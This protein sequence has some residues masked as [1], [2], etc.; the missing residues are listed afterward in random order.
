M[1]LVTQLYLEQVSQWPTSG[2]HIL[3][4]YDEQH[5]V[6][7]QAYS[8]SIGTFAAQHGYFGDDYKLNRMSWIKPNFLWM[9][10]RSGWATKENQEVILA[11]WINRE[12]FETILRQ[13]VHT[14]FVADIYGTT[15]QWKEALNLASVRLQWDPDHDPTGKPLTRRAI[16]LGLSGEILAQF[17]QGGWIEYI[18]DITSFVHKEHLFAKEDYFQLQVPQERVYR[19]AS[20]EIAK[21]LQLS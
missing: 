19:I 16:Q 15:E 3:A 9:M 6:V 4:Q 18:E 12:N 7:Y 17:A 5:I 10:Y 14:S 21:K 20:A 11:L 2:K 8:H 1:R 13:A